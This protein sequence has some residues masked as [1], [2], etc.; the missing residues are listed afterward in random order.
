[1][2]LLNQ[3]LQ[4]LDARRAA[5]GVGNPLPNAVRPLPKPQASRLPMVL[6]MLVLT[7]L[8]GGSAFLYWEIRQ[9]TAPSALSGAPPLAP[10]PAVLTTA[11][12]PP[13]AQLAVEPL[14]SLQAEPALPA[15]W[16]A[17]DGGP[18]TSTDS[19]GSLPQPQSEA[20]PAAASSVVENGFTGDRSKL[21][22]IEQ[23]LTAPP[24]PSPQRENRSSRIPIIERSDALGSSTDRPETEYRKA[25][26][27]LNQG[28]VAE[29]LEGL[30][31]ALRQDGSH[32]ASRQVLVRL[33]LEARRLDEAVQ[34]L[35]EGLLGQPEQ[36][37]WAMTLARL[38]LDRGDLSGAWKTLDHSLPAAGNNADYQ[39]FT[40]HL[41]Q[42]L[43]RNEEAAEH[44]QAATR[45]APGDGRWWL[46][47]GL[48][49][50]ADGRSTEARD[51]LHMAKAA[52]TLSAELTAWVE[53]KLR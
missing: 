46:G 15:G 10:A 50:E 4:D 37:G 25:I 48:A 11:S 42:R 26:A 32:V 3:M 20:K 22:A 35:Q 8:A 36:I 29:A 16:A 53:Q 13:L 40:A 28:A 2:S 38:Q 45:V 18:R 39:G 41:L 5:Q 17:M 6:G 30:R 52:G 14:K 49:W 19:V 51:A 23:P 21:A 47:L 9:E 12:P 34:V 27:S 31:N 33:L 7:F 44:Y 24:W 43:G 1:M